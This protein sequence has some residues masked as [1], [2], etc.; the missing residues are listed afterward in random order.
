MQARSTLGSSKPPSQLCPFD[1]AVI[2]DR[3]ASDY[4][5][6]I[7][8]LTEVSRILQHHQEDV[9]SVYSNTR[10]ISTKQ[11][12]SSIRLRFINPSSQS[13]TP[14]MRQCGLYLNYNPIFIK[15]I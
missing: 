6:P 7:T 3:S 14:R 15:H 2:H 12:S 13:L 10:I 4:A 9:Q 5:V 1:F 11:L 8:Q